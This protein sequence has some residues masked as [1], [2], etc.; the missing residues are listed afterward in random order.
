MECHLVHD[1]LL[2]KPDP[3][4]VRYQICSL[5]R[6]VMLALTIRDYGAS[7]PELKTIF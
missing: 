7:S 4:S 6:I 1:A 3:A 2:T 5:C